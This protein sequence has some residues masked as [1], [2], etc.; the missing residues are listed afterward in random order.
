MQG[1][2]LFLKF[3]IDEVLLKILPFCRDPDPRVRFAVFQTIGTL[4]VDFGFDNKET[5]GVVLAERYHAQI[6]QAILIGL[7]DSYKTKKKGRKEREKKR[8]S[9][10]KVQRGK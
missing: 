8:N 2:L 3:F 1:T 5:T 9:N 4:L 7:A 10:K 6:V